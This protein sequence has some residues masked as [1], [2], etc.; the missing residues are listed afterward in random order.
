MYD[1]GRLTGTS[2]IPIELTGTSPPGGVSPDFH[3]AAV[4]P[5]SG[6]QASGC[7]LR[8]RG[9]G[10]ALAYP[11][12]GLSGSMTAAPLSGVALA[13]PNSS[14]SVGLGSPR[15]LTSWPAS[16]SCSRRRLFGA[17]PGLAAASSRR[18][19]R[20]RR[21]A[22]VEILGPAAAFPRRLP[23]PLRCAVVGNLGPVV[24]S[25]RCPRPWRPA[26]RLRPRPWRR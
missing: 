6:P 1:S 22:V 17:R 16:I 10:L 3:V 5:L 7:G 18:L 9:S 8:G 25:P 19:P 14:L 4:C 20:S 26:R 24:A 12:P 15:G 11:N 23:G 2:P 21:R 13:Y